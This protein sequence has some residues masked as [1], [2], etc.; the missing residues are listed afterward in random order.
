[1]R[2]RV[3]H[4]YS[5][6]CKCIYMHMTV[7]PNFDLSL[8]THGMHAHTRT[9]IHTRTRTH[10]CTYFHLIYVFPSSMCIFAS[11]CFLLKLYMRTRARTHAHREW[12]VEGLLAKVCAS[13]CVCMCGCVRK[14]TLECVRGACRM[15]T[16]GIACEIAN[17]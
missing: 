5:G 13:R 14:C 16:N 4:S 1:L 8:H 10:E 7:L 12:I 3:H 9:H 17:V 11:V 2:A 15:I 6:P